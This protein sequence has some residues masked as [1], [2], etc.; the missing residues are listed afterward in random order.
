MLKNGQKCH[1]FENSIVRL[2]PESAENRQI[3][4]RRVRLV[5]KSSQ[6]FFYRKRTKIDDFIPKPTPMTPQ[7][8]ERSNLMFVVMGVGGLVLFAIIGI[9]LSFYIMYWLII[10]LPVLIRIKHNEL[11]NK[12]R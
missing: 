6:K 9:V 7:K 1:I 5:P 8:K 12:W 10:E 3:C 11:F 4:G 2:W